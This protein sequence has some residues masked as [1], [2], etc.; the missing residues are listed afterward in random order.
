M[1]LSEMIHPPEH[2]QTWGICSVYLHPLFKLRLMMRP[3]GVT[4]M[5]QVAAETPNSLLWSHHPDNIIL[6]FSQ[7]A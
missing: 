3:A 2:E 4:S 6:D 7:T 5:H 1:D